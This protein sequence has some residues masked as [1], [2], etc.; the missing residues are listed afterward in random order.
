M[1]GFRPFASRDVS[2]SIGSCE[3]KYRSSLVGKLRYT[4]ALPTPARSAMTS[5]PAS[6]PSSVNTA[7]AARVA[8]R[9]EWAVEDSLPE[10]AALE[11][12]LDDAASRGERSAEAARE[13][14]ALIGASVDKVEGGSRLVSDAGRTMAEI[15]G[16]V[17]RV[18]DIVN[19]IGAASSEQSEGIGQVDGAVA[20]L[21]HM[22][23]QNAALV[24]QSAAAA[25]SLRE[26]AANLAQV[27]GRFRL[28]PVAG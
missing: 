1:P 25:D 18:C 11:H 10:Q 8:S 23:Q 12:W 13:I 9:A 24:E 14:K 28:E 27:I 3:P 17:R 4:V 19:E 5:T 15:V 20:Q 6:G 2:V 22:T 21:D 16:S 26:Q 7:A